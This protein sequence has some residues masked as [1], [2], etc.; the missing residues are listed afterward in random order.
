MFESISAT[1]KGSK[2]QELDNIW[3]VPKMSHIILDSIP[4]P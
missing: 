2:V 3:K 1:N 4:K